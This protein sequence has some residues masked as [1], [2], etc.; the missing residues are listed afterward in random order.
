MIDK[1][2]PVLVTGGS[3]YIASHIIQ[4]LLEQGYKIN[5]TVR[6]KSK[7]A[8]VAHLM[9]LQEQYPKHLRFYEADLLKDGSFETAMTNCELVIHTASPFKLNVKDAQKELVDPALKGTQNVLQQA[10]Q[11]ATVK[12][13][14]LT[15]SVVAIYGDAI[16]LQSTE[17]NQFTE[18]EWN[19]TS[20]LRHQPY[21]Y[22]KTLAEREAWDIQS[23]QTQWDLVVINPG[24]V[25]GP[26]LSKR[27]DGESTSFILQLLEGGFKSG[28]PALYFGAA[29]VRDVA[30]AHI[31]A[32]TTPTASGRHILVENTYSMLEMSEMIEQ[33]FP[34]KYKLPT[35]KLPKF[36]LFLVGPFIGFSWKFISRNVEHPMRFDN[37]YS[38]KDLGLS[39]RP[40]LQ[41]LKEQAEQLEADG[42]IKR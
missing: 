38:Q 18:H 39:Y 5:T 12:R 41:T 22:S 33:S 42:L 31:L 25:L 10:N 37:T 19:T 9:L 27:T 30:K 13:V 32:G 35:K 11:T 28:A 23:K 17:G 6:N 36:L 21:A 24:F 26:S 40:M 8:K 14:V 2:K 16:D 4:Q 7:M 29:D 34:N 3:G 15:S 1:N 20:S